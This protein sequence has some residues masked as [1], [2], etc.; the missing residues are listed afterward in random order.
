MLC[1]REFGHVCAGLG[2]H[3][4]GSETADA[5]DG[6]DQVKETAKGFHHHLDLLG[7]RCEGRGVLVD[8]AQVQAGRECVVGV[9][10]TEGFSELRDFLRS[11]FWARSAMVAGSVSPASKAPSIARDEA[12]WRSAATE[13]S[14][15]RRSSSSLSKRWI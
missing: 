2:D 13:D 6:A 15:I 10:P 14:S 12:P 1:G 8:E 3:D 9:E 11:C 5:R 7:E 4:V